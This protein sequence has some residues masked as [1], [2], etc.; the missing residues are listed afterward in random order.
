L[1]AL[2]RSYKTLMFEQEAPPDVFGFAWYGNGNY[3]PNQIGPDIEFMVNEM[4][5]P[6]PAAVS[7]DRIALLEG[8]CDQRSNP[9]RL[10]FYREAIQTV[11]QLG[12]KGIAVWEADAY[13]NLA[14]D[15]S[16]GNTDPNP[17]FSLFITAFTPRGNTSFPTPGWTYNNRIYDNFPKYN[18]LPLSP[19]ITPDFGATFFS[20]SW[21]EL[22]YQS[23]TTIGEV[24]RDAFAA[25]V[26]Q[27]S[28]RAVVSAASFAGSGS[29]SPGELVTLFGESLGPERGAT[30]Q[31]DAHGRV[32]TSLA[33][34]RVLFNG[35]PAPVLY[36]QFA[37][38]NA[39]V[40]YALTP[41]GPATVEV[42][43]SGQRTSPLQVSVIGAE[44][45]IF[46]ADS[47][48]SGHT[49]ALNEDGT[50]NSASNPARLR[51]IIT[52][53][54]T[55]AGQ[56]DPSGVDGQLASDPLPKPLAQL[57]VVLNGGTSIEVLYAGAGP[58]LVAGV[59][60][61][62]AR[63]PDSASFPLGAVPI[64]VTANGQS[65]PFQAVTIAVR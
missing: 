54:G 44:F 43:Y 30:F 4:G 53:F 49:A 9:G 15:Q 55:G 19:Q 10:L 29:I 12:L 52:I 27:P 56:T 65:P 40:P 36:S 41:P 58:G 64:V 11:D 17:E 21:G 34:T 39:I 28:L 62:N 46:T 45:S 2:I 18:G 51:S 14:P 31:L 20:T 37:Q 32:G 63:L 1:G 26:P 25:T 47:S 13:E 16:G 23:L 33:G 3:D 48:G 7:P 35:I 6:E 61:I 42:E 8:G 5:K 59:T 60:Q 38:V 22:A 24:V 57:G 50:V